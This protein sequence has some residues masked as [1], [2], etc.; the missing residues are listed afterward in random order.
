[1]AFSKGAA[2]WSVLQSKFLHVT[3]ADLNHLSVVIPIAA[4]AFVGIEIISAAAIEVK[5]PQNNLPTPANYIAP[6]VGLIY[7]C[8]LLMFCLNIHWEDPGLPPFYGISPSHRQHALQRKDPDFVPESSPATHSVMVL[9]VQHAGMK[10][11]ASFLMAALIFA[12]E[13]T[14][15]IALYVASR[16]LHGLT[17][18]MDFNSEFPVKRWIAYLSVTNG[19]RVPSVALLASAFAFGSWLPA[20]N[21]A[22]ARP[23]V[24]DVGISQSTTFDTNLT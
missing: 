4:Y 24:G 18:G 9:A 20:V 23:T 22:R 1:M 8:L 14:A 12:A 15:M 7:M 5:K 2:V 21:F 16:T 13:N 17:R 6:V 3:L 19:Q 11:L 10:N